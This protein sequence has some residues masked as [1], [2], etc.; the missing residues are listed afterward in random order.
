MIRPLELINTVLLAA[1]VVLLAML[2]FTPPAPVATP[3]PEVPLSIPTIECQ[4]GGLF[5]EAEQLECVPVRALDA[6]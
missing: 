3:E 5:E 2:V 6:P 4:I 1:I